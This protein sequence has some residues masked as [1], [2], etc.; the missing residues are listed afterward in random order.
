MHSDH[1]P[2]GDARLLRRVSLASVLVALML[3]IVKAAAWFMTDSVSLLAS[4][5]D[6]VMDSAASMI[7]LL[8]IRFAL[9]PAD[10]EHRYGHGKAEALAGLGQA[11]FIAGS[12]VFLM[13]YAVDRLLHPVPVTETGT[14]IA[15]MLFSI[16]AT[17]GL[18]LF[19]R[20]VIRRTR[21]TAISADSLHY[22]GD[23][24]VNAS[25]IV[26]L[27][28][29]GAG[30]QSVDAWM[31]IAI[32]LYILWNAWQIVGD[33]MVDLLD[34]EVDEPVR[35]E[36]L[37]L[38]VAQ[39]EVRG[40]HDLRTRVSGRQMFVQLHLELDRDLPL[41]RAHEAADG[42]ERSIR[43]R[44]PGSDVIVHQDPVVVAPGAP[45]GGDTR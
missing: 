4:L 26:A 2:A 9:T 10:D 30:Y 35:E 1:D 17:A 21:S 43:T 39:T 28:A 45:A 20:Y 12:A 40:V 11:A 19:Q 23:L 29:A 42:V 6:S 14:G 44:F 16:V 37:R 36:I 27:L 24:L 22:V 25:I 31:G 33:S 8:A 7:N 3:I 15:V 41:W 18:V 38:A 34:R 32:A 5:V 13:V